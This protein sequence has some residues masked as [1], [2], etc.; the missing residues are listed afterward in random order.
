M[1]EIMMTSIPTAITAIITYFLTRRKYLVDVKKAKAEAKGNEIDNVE[2]AVK[3]WRELTEDL[4]VHFKTDISDLRADN[5]LMHSQLEQV[6]KENNSLRQQMAS[7]EKELKESKNENIKLSEQ[8]KQFNQNY[9]NREL[10]T[11][12]K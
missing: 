12:N 9:H 2:K 4:K 3:I 11:K 1:N 7:L 6:L 8:L 5:K 10:K